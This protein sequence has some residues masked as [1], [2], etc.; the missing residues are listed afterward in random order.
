MAA[1]AE[2]SAKL[3]VASIWLDMWSMPW[4]RAVAGLVILCILISVSFYV[5]AR[6]RDRAGDAHVELSFSDSKLEEMLRRGDISE[7]EYRTIK[8]KSYGVSVDRDGSPSLQLVRE[9]EQPMATD[10]QRKSAD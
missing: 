7:S 6:F 1:I 9:S 5:V 4:V 3:L 2:T 10:D 8:S